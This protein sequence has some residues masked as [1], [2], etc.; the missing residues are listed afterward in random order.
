MG[1]WDKRLN[2]SLLAFRA[3]R[4]ANI[5]AVPKSRKLARIP[6]GS[7]AARRPR[8]DEPRAPVQTGNLAGARLGYEGGT[9]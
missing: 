8:P 2:S 9:I 6:V 3:H 7:H 4:H 5:D 1:V